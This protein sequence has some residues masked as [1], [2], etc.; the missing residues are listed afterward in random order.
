MFLSSCSG[1]PRTNPI[2]LALPTFLSHSFFHQLSTLKKTH[3]FPLCFLFHALKVD[4]YLPDKLSKGVM[5]NM[6]FVCVC[7]CGAHTNKCTCL[8][9]GVSETG[10]VLTKGLISSIMVLETFWDAS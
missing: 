2:F 10:S 3:N 4:C 1:P 7:V 5:A 6:V 8:L 9:I